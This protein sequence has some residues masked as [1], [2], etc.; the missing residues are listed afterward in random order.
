[1]G[2]TVDYFLSASSPWTYLGHPRLVAMAA[3]YG[4]RIRPRPV[5][6][7]RIFAATGGLPLN[8]RP[9]ARR[10]YRD[11]ELKRWK[12]WL[13]DPIKLEPKFFPVSA[14]GAGR[15]VIAAEPLGVEVQLRL[16]YAAMREVFV[17]DRNIAE[18]PT[19][20]ALV[21]REGLPATLVA[22]SDSAQVRA[23]YDAYT[24]EAIE[25]KVF[26]APTYIVDGEPF[27]GQDRLDFVER[28]LARP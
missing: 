19:L 20:A 9:P 2:K 28:A 12:A 13:N 18:Q 6:F 3:R 24:E 4:A 10:A 17:E 11:W 26:G 23:R 21:A 22:D 15:L 14:A 27:W 1:V 16:A 5:D 25:R 7:G 8:A